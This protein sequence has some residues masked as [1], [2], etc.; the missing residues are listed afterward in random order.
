MS[1]HLVLPEDITLEEAE[2]FA[3][4]VRT[5]HPDSELG[6]FLNALYE[7]IKDGKP[8]VMLANEVSQ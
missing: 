6:R 2:N 4:F 1:A 5:L 8:F 3:S 7:L